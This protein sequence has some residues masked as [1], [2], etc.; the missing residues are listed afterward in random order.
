MPRHLQ[1]YAEGLKKQRDKREH[2][3]LV[4]QAGG[5]IRIDDAKECTFKPRVGPAPR[6]SPSASG[7]AA[8]GSPTVHERLYEDSIMK[9]AALASG[10]SAS[11]AMAALTEDLGQEEAELQAAQAAAFAAQAASAAGSELLEQQ[12]QQAAALSTEA[13]Q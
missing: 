6:G 4:A 8:P 1:L 2:A 13:L 10:S 9:R 11:L 5:L 12:L 3:E 7:S